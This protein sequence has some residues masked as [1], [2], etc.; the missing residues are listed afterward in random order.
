MD[1]ELD[2]V[3]R[4]LETAVEANQI[5]GAV[6]LVRHRGETVFH[7][8]IG[9]TASLPDS[10]PMQLDTLFDLASLTKPL[11]GATVALS[12][13]DQGILSLDEEVTKFVPELKSLRGEGVTLRSLLSHTSGLAGWRP[14]YAWAQDPKGVLS[15]IDRMGLVTRPGT[16]SEYSDIGF[17]TLGLAL[18]RAGDQPLDELAAE[19]IFEELGLEHTG[20]RPSA[21]SD[22]F[23]VTELGNAFERRMAE[24]AGL[25]FD[26]W[27]TDF[28]PGEVNDGNAHYAM[29]GVSAHAGLFSNAADVGVLGEMWLGRAKPA[30]LSRAVME[31][32]TTDQTPH[33]SGRGLGWQL[34]RRRGSTLEELGRTQAGFFPPAETPWSPQASGE[35]FSPAAFGHTGFTGTSIWIDPTRE[36]VAVLLTNATH[37]S[38]DIDKPTNVLRAKFHNAVVASLDSAT[39]RRETS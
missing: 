28:H 33:G 29:A 11:V 27:R 24:W 36:L 15:A 17:V 2:R 12:M 20:F 37:P 14:L 19:L 1:P 9:H 21:P 13:V 39:S 26:G 18:Q 10:R 35:L 6:A 5:P 4:V 34:M 16:R 23:A 38:V 7:E 3:S 32:A 30:V 31:L 8:A 25:E 22:A